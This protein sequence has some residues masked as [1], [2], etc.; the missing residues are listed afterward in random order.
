[1]ANIIIFLRSIDL[2]LYFNGFCSFVTSKVAE[3]E[4]FENR[5]KVVKKVIF[6]C[7]A[8]PDPTRTRFSKS[9]ISF[10]IGLTGL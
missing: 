5:K 9:K 4:L 7:H 10:N 8:P 6:W 3:L 1:M 2:R